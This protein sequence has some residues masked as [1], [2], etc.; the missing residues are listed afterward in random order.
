MKVLISILLVLSCLCMLVACQSNDVGQS[1]V[2]E[3]QNGTNSENY[4]MAI[5]FIEIGNYAE[6][7]ELLMQ[8]TNYL[9]TKEILS[10]FTVQYGEESW[11]VERY[12]YAGIVTET[13]TKR[14]QYEFDSQGLILSV[15]QE[16]DKI[17]Q[18]TT[19]T[20]NANGDKT[21]VQS[22]DQEGVLLARSVYEYNDKGLL[23]F[24]KNYSGTDKYI[25]STRYEYDANGNQTLKDFDSASSR[26]KEMW[27]YDANGN[28][29][30]HALEQ[31]SKMQYKYTY[32][33]D[34]HGNSILRYSYDSKDQITYINAYT[35]D[36]SGNLVADAQYYDETRW[37]KDQWSDKVVYQYDANG[38]LLKKENLTGYGNPTVRS[39]SKYEYDANGNVTLYIWYKE[40]GTEMQRKEYT[41]HPNGVIKSETVIEDSSC[42]VS[43]YNTYGEMT[44]YV[45]SNVDSG[46]VYEKQTYT[47]QDRY[48][49]YTP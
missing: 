11:I 14:T 15:I 2:G 29:I 30:L 23:V 27:E 47:Y 45:R 22:Y 24:V 3:T 28:M 4:N 12:N 32:L 7:Y 43:H 17:F 25:S 38:N 26:F 16:D 44:E 13:I 39:S 41:Y 1:Q 36:D 48:I 18:K 37:E 46:Q 49:T 31:F 8:N 40:D 20:Y 6:A 21:L 10:H 33:Y 35:Y 34:E 5:A 42:T 19:Y 9:D